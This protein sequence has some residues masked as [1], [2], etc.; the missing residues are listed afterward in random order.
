[1]ERRTFIIG[2]AGGA[3]F[4]ALWALYSKWAPV[5]GPT[6]VG[7]EHYLRFGERAALEALTPHADFY[8]TSKGVTPQVDAAA[9]RLSVS[10]LVDNPLTITLDEV[11]AR[12]AIERTLTLE[13]ISNRIGGPWI[14][15]AVW[16]GT[17]L[18]PLLEQARPRAEAVS[19]LLHG[20]DGLSSGIP[21]ERLLAEDNLLAYEMNGEPLPPV[22]GYPLRVFIPGKYGM[23]Q[24]KWLTGI[25]FTA[26]HKLGFWERRGWSDTAERQ[27]RAVT[28]SPRE[29]VRLTGERFLVAGYAVAD[30]SGIARVEISADDGKT[31]QSAEI[32]SNPSPY[33]WTF[34]KYE[35][36]PPAP[37]GYTL[38]ARAVNGRGEL[39]PAEETAP[40]PEGA[41]GYHRIAVEV[42]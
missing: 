31:W 3:W 30:G 19:A 4:A 11:K 42:G 29:K 21:L 23:K 18:R 38:R 39:Q 41:T 37:G 10:G 13:C 22:H 15:N 25:E 7:V 28:D 34:W 8:V 26:E 35:W 27:T 1:M 12:P 14:G 33:V 6:R 24:P 2:I 40:Q 17:A 36:T 9:W 32:V 16:R 5:S 20:A